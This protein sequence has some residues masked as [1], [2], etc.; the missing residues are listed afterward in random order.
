MG[1]SYTQLE[2][3]VN[4]ILAIALSPRIGNWLRQKVAQQLTDS[5][6]QASNRNPLLD[7]WLGQSWCDLNQ[8]FMDERQVEKFLDRHILRLAATRH[9]GC[10]LTGTSL[11]LLG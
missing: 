11:L 6:Q 10:C 3:D 4:R 1:G 7:S 9:D 5:S 2:G 8:G